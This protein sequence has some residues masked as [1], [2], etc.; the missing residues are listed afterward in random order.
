MNILRWIISAPLS[1]AMLVGGYF[2][3][4]LILGWLVKILSVVMLWGSRW[5][6]SSGPQIDDFKSFI[7]VTC[8]STLIASGVAGYFGGRVPPE[9]HKKAVGILYSL[10]V[11]PLLVLSA[12]SFW[13]GD[14]IFYS[15]I[16]VL[17]MVAVYIIFISSAVYFE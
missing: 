12:A 16:W 4:E 5:N 17:D 9:G 7:F 6:I 13:N 1:L 11:I 8:L 2:V 3:T 10:A 14:H 15:I